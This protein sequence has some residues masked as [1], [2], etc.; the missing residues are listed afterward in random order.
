[1]QEPLY[2]SATQEE[3]IDSMISDMPNLINIP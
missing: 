1:M 2:E 3:P